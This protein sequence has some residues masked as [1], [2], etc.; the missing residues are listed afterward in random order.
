[1]DDGATSG[2]RL[3]SP[4]R[5]A[6][7]KR[8]LIP[9]LLR[10]LPGGGRYVEPFAG[11]ACLFFERQPASAVLADANAELMGAYVALRA[12]PEDV[13]DRV[14]QWAT[15]RDTYYE[16]RALDPELLEPET[17]AAR[18]I[19]L[20]RLCFNGVYRTNRQGHFNVPYG[21]R[22]GAMPSRDRFRAA[23]RRLAA[24]QLRCG[25]F[26]ATTHDVRAG[27]VVYLDPPYTQRPEAAYGLYGYGSFT[28]LD[29]PRFAST[30]RRLDA[31]GAAVVVSYADTPE[32]RELLADWRVVELSARA[33]VAARTD[34]RHKRQELLL[35]NTQCQR[36]LVV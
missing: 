35:L 33:R 25:D 27:D 12:K 16:V 13:A 4:L 23:G 8:D 29:L 14:W 10:W 1:M 36:R 28:A 30:C 26:D 11:S 22:P 17:R 21:S 19:Y 3:T 2:E 34:R 24:A 18:F 15:D 6:G 31:T 7:S 9:E 32:I 5:W 20:N